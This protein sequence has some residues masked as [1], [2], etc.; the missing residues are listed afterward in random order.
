[1]KLFSKYIPTYVITVNERHRQTDRLTDRQTIYCGITALCVALHSKND[2]AGPSTSCPVDIIFVQYGYVPLMVRTYLLHLVARLDIDSGH[3]RV[4]LVIF[5]DNV[6]QHINL[7]EHSTVASFQSTIAGFN[8]T[9][10]SENVTNVLRYVRT[11][12]LTSEAGDRSDARNIIVT[13]IG[14]SL[15]YMT[16][17]VCTVWKF[18][19]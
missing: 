3:T 15:N 1:M 8:E 11:K 17:K 6:E 5:S 10:G 16:A 18:F 14:Q 7:N 12:M 4:G 2:I 19:F 9:Y 13:V